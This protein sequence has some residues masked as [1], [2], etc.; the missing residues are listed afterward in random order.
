[1]DRAPLFLM[2]VSFVLLALN[3]FRAIL[4]NKR[5]RKKLQNVESLNRGLTQDNDSLRRQIERDRNEDRARRD[6]YGHVYDASYKEVQQDKRTGRW[7]TVRE[8]NP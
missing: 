2:V 4:E 8:V 3:A 1:M 6:D 7:H 5:L